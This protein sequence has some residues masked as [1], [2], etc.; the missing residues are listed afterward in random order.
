M[1]EPQLAR[2]AAG[3]HLGGLVGDRDAVWFSDLVGGGMHRLNADGSV[4][5]W[6]EDR[7]WMAGLVLNE[8]GSMLVSGASGISWVDPASG[9]AGTLLDSFEG[10]PLPG[11]NEMCPDREG[12]LY[13]GT[14]DLPSIERGEKP[15]PVG[16]YH[17]DVEGSVRQLCDGLVFTNGIEISPDGGTLYHNE[18]FVGTFAYAIA[19]DGGLG[20]RTMVIEKEDCDGI[21]ID[22]DGN[23]W[24]SGFFSQEVVCLA[25]DGSVLRQLTLSGGGVSNV[26]FGGDGGRYLYATVVAPGASESLRAGRP[27]TERDSV[28]YRVSGLTPGR[29][30]PRTRFTLK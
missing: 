2:V 5:N 6:L 9:E 13:F 10:R 20:E 4:E 11:V 17:L 27:L 30:V 24:I 1:T 3:I 15:R 22:V 28:L 23:L 25:T 12:G 21:A 26:S 19:A 7:R 8:D 18:S 29:M 14:V 16:I